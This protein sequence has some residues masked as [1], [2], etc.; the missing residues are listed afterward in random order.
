MVT[1]IMNNL[2]KQLRLLRKAAYF[3]IKAT[4][5]AGQPVLVSYDGE[6]WVHRWS[7]GAFVS[8]V[9]I[10]RPIFECSVS[11]PLFTYAYAPKRGDT[12]LDIGAGVGTELLAFS[13]MVG[14]SGRVIA[15]EADPTAYRCLEKLC[16]LMRL[17]NVTLVRS[18]VGDFEGLSRFTQD[19]G[20]AITNALAVD[21]LSGAIEVPVTT[22]DLLIKKL[23]L[24]SVDFLKMNIEGAEVPALKGFHE[25]AAIVR[26]WCISCHD[27]HGTP[28]CFTFEFVTKWLSC[29]GLSVSRHPDVPGSPWMG[30]YVFAS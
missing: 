27:F 28:E 7:S 13:K 24:E 4:K 10:K 8:P 17:D 20:G 15:I 5:K 6:D 23:G 26:N 29:R 14:A 1:E 16:R 30:Y 21:P 22:L 12:I 2:G 18:A 11:I 19:A 9:P 25:Q 3:S